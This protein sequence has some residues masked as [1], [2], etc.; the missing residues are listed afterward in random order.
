MRTRARALRRFAALVFG[1]GLL[2]LASLDEAK[3]QDTATP[4]APT[5]SAPSAAA[6]AERIFEQ[7][8]KRLDAG[9]FQGACP[10]L[11]QSEQLDPS[12]GTLLN[13][14]DCYEHV[15]RTASA[16]AA[17]GEAARLASATGRADRVQVAELR[18]DRLVDKL[19]RLRP[20]PP[21][22]PVV[23]L[24][25]YLDDRPLP[26]TAWSAPVAVD[27]GRHAF[28]ATAPGRADLVQIL[29]APAAGMTED[30]PIPELA[31]AGP[32]PSDAERAA[33]ADRSGLG[34]QRTVA[35]A[36]A[37][38]G[39]VGLIVGSIFGVR[40]I[41]KHHASDTHCNGDICADQAGVA[42]MDSARAAG[43][44]STVAFVVGGVGLGAAAVLWFVPFGRPA[45]TG[46]AELGFGPGTARL[47]ATW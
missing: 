29:V 11:E 4:K 9:D 27:P 1:V 2:E 37:G 19:R 42:L 16:W 41:A 22:L 12:S 28:R 24:S 32:A 39:S 43:N 8:V 44:V 7:A 3:A 45:A 33:R 36:S 10:L 40:S 46:T 13:L 23:G 38:V 30:V 14:A 35:L 5:S 6:E 47:R 17:F 15:G 26:S 21:S 18:R 31:L 25:L 34:P 20:L